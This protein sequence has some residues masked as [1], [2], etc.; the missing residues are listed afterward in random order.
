MENSHNKKVF[1]AWYN[2]LEKTDF[3]A[4]CIMAADQEGKVKFICTDL[5]SAGD[6]LPLIKEI[7]TN[8]QKKIKL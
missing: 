5:L 2:K 1:R 7:Y 3:K 8:I 6:C 4:F